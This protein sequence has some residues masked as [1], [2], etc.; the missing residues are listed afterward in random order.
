MLAEIT[1][2]CRKY[3]MP[4]STFGRLAVGDPRLISDLRQG[5]QLR[6]TTR[7]T[8]QNFIGSYD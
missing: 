8:I 2:F 3:K 7:Q 4:E 5:R 1:K 6:S